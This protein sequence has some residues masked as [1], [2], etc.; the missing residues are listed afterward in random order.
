M[1]PKYR[2]LVG[3]GSTLLFCFPVGFTLITKTQGQWETRSRLEQ[4]SQLT[5]NEVKVALQ[6]AQVCEQLDP[7]LPLSNNSYA[8]Y[9]HSPN[10]PLPAG[11]LVCDSDGN[12]AIID[13]TGHAVGLKSAPPEQLNKVIETRT[14]P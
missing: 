9:S 12:T 4:S 8:H 1:N 7:K 3:A 5:L 2:S 10:R 14:K 11:K 6:R 13:E